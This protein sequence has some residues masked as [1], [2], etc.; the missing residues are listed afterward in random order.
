MSPKITLSHSAVIQLKT[1]ISAEVTGTFLRVSVKG[2]GCHGFQYQFDLDTKRTPE[3]CVFDQDGVRVVLDP[4]SL[5][6]LEGSEIDYK[7]DLMGAAFVLN[8][9]KAASSCGCGNSFSL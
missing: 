6:I 1:I 9:P 2:G 7:H 4:L 8:N 3:D 5:E